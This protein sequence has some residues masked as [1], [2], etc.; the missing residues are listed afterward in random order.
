MTETTISELA[1]P[2]SHPPTEA[3]QLIPPPARSLFKSP[4]EI[5]SVPALFRVK[6]I[7]TETYRTYII[8]NVFFL[9][10]YYTGIQ[11]WDYAGLKKDA[12][13]FGSATRA[14]VSTGNEKK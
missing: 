4:A 12:N 5:V 10:N 13:L 9:S 8:K 7:L 14:P 2:F 3:R 1:R 6:S 11:V